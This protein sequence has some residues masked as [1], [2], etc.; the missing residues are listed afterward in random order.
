MALLN[1]PHTGSPEGKGRLQ[2]YG[3]NRKLRCRHGLRQQELER[4]SPDSREHRE[5]PPGI[6]CAFCPEVT[7]RA[8]GSKCSLF[9]FT[10]QP[11]RE[12]FYLS[13]HFLRNR[14]IPDR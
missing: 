1:A 12:A 6:A 14:Q 11:G 9:S 10:D 13:R 3:E 8:Q 2:S 7:V 4:N 5:P